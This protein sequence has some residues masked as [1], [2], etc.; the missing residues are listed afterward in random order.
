MNITLI[1]E[2]VAKTGLHFE[3]KKVVQIQNIEVYY[4]RQGSW[5]C[6]KCI[7]QAPHVLHFS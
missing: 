2:N 1:L 6:S 3:R 7:G 4:Q 5:L